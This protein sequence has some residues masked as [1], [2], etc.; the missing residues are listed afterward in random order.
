MKLGRIP[1]LVLVLTM[2]SVSSSTFAQTGCKYWHCS[3]S[4]GSATCSIL[5]CGRAP[6]DFPFAL[7]CVG[8]CDGPGCWCDTQGE[9]YDV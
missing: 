9:C 7:D 1:L 2:L 4:A 8:V 3:L 6:C 5:F